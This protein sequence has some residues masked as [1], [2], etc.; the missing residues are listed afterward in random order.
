MS[1]VNFSIIKFQIKAPMN[2]S[3]KL[4]QKVS[5]LAEPLSLQTQFSSSLTKTKSETPSITIVRQQESAKPFGQD[6]YDQMGALRNFDEEAFQ[7]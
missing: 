7:R 1:E 5:L 2:A 4:K 3:H 6:N